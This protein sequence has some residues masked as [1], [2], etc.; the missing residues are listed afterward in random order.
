MPEQNS[1]SYIRKRDGRVVTFNADKITD[2]I[3]KSAEAVGGSDRAAAETITE[4]VIGILS[5]IYKDGRMPTV[6]NVQDLVEKMLIE[7][8]HAKV[9]KAF[10]LYR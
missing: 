3:F 9:A 2:A 4:S 1:I 7:R 8:G 10:I 5:I 6:E